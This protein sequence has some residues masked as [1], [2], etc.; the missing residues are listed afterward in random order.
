MPPAWPTR[1]ERLQPVTVPTRRGAEQLGS[2]LQTLARVELTD[3]FSFA[4]LVAE[5]AGRI[6]RDATAV[7]IVASVTFDTAVA[8]GELR[9]KGHRGYSDCEH[10]R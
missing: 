6:P 3:G 2:I 4:D 5:A 10:V 8:L 1:S 9:H 7:A